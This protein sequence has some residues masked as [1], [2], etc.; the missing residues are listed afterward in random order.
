MAL[1]DVVFTGNPPPSFTTPGSSA[2]IT[3]T[4]STAGSGATVTIGVT[5]T[6]ISSVTT[7]PAAQ[8][9]G[10]PPNATIYFSVSGGTGGIV[11]GT[12]D[13]SSVLT[14]N[15]TQVVAGSGYTAGT[16]STTV[17]FIGNP[18]TGSTTLFLPYQTAMTGSGAQVTY[19]ASAGAISTVTATP[20]NVGSG[21]P[22]NVSFYLLVS[23][24]GS[25]GFVTA[26]TN[27]SGTVSN[28]TTSPYGGTGYSSTTANT[29]VNFGNPYVNSGTITAITG[30]GAAGSGYPANC[31]L[32]LLLAG[33][34]GGIAYVTTDNSGGGGTT[35]KVVTYSG[36]PISPGSGYTSGTAATTVVAIATSG[37]T[38]LV[39][40]EMNRGSGTLSDIIM[41]ASLYN[42][43]CNEMTRGNVGTLSDLSAANPIS[44]LA[45]GN[46]GTLAEILAGH[47]NC[48]ELAN[49]NYVIPSTSNVKIGV[50]YGNNNSLTG[51]LVV[52]GSVSGAVTLTRVTGSQAYGGSGTCAQLTPTSTTA[53]GYWY[54][55]IP[56]TGG[57]A[58]PFS[59]YHQISSGWN[60]ILNVTIYDAYLEGTPGVLLSQ[61]VTTID[62]GQYNQQLCSAVTPTDTGMCLVV[63]GI[64]NGSVS[65]YVLIDNIG[66]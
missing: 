13:N 2:T 39:N 14:F 12:T 27:S 28:F 32:Y 38:F 51:T 19:V 11:K 20:A 35:G 54:F 41:G 65:G 59:F 37:G 17:V 61:T 1:T 6:A 36:T 33:G 24:G 52:G 46:I 22:P 48:N 44:E 15:A 50:T 66:A 45:R 4:A 60:G 29:S 43:L 3:F 18:G 8:G 25:N 34:T 9:S 57:I 31:G 47:R 56:V 55:Y 10:Y 23:G 42:N 64:Q 62:N 49:A 53:F 30:I 26:T 63:I 21:Y 58:F 40:S 5:S 7:T 16:K